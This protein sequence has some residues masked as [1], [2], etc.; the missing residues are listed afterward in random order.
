METNEFVGS[1]REFEDEK[2]A[3]LQGG[4]TPYAPSAAIL[5]PPVRFQTGGAP[6]PFD[7]LNTGRRQTHRSHALSHPAGARHPQMETMP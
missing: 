6:L 5:Q 2:L 1:Q 3:D 7:A 4:F